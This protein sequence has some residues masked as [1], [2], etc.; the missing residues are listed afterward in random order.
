VLKNFPSESELRSV[1]EGLCSEL[2]YLAWQHYWAVEYMAIA[3]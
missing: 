1:T 3:A 2:R